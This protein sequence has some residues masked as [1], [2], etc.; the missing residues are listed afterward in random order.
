MMSRLRLLPIALLAG[1]LAFAQPP[2]QA[3]LFDGTLGLKVSLKELFTGDFNARQFLTQVFM[4][5][6]GVSIDLKATDSR[7]AQIVL[8]NQLYGPASSE[9][10]VTRM[11][12]IE[13]PRAGR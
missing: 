11:L 2:A 6:F 13:S 10:G 4:L 7:G 1:V 5:A 8:D 9:A 12:G 3:Q